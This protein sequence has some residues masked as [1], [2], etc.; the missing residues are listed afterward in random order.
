ME[1]LTKDSDL[2]QQVEKVLNIT[3]VIPKHTHNGIDSQVISDVD[4]S[5]TTTIAAS[6]NPALSGDVLLAG[7]TNISLTQVGQTITITGS[8][9]GLTN[10]GLFGDG[11]DGNFTVSGPTTLTRDMFYNN[12]IIN[13]GQVLTANGFQL[14]VAGTLTINGTG[15][16]VYNGNNGSSG[17]AGGSGGAGTPG[18]GGTGATALP[19]GTLPGGTA[20][21]NGG[22]G[23]NGHT[24]SN[25]T[26][27]VNGDGGVSTNPSMGVNGLNGTTNSGGFSGNAGG[28]TGASGGTG[29]GG[30]TATPALNLPHAVPGA[31]IHADLLATYTQHQDSAGTGGAGGGAGGAANSGSSGGGGGGGGS[32]GTGGVI[33]IYA[34]TI[35]NNSSPGIQVLGGTGGNGGAGANAVGGGQGG[36][37]GGGAGGGGGTGG[38]II[39]VYL[40]LTQNGTFDVT[41]GA[42]GTGGALGIH[43]GGSGASDGGTGSDGGQGNS[44][45]IWQ[46]QLT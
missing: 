36:G 27:G 21:A 46:L 37:G 13:T 17:T 2:T 35:I 41:G 26:A 14:F 1:P 44:G 40:T 11:S 31:Y 10:V 7:G 12:L 22:G 25:G 8:A 24:T 32:G 4:T 43:A 30:G 18:V 39:L 6:G 3:K 20:G 45:K 9:S 34:N 19:G 38:V 28:F 29:G 16:I 42:G 23:G 5:T 33:A 15:K